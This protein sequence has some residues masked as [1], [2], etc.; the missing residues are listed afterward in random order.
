MHDGVGH[1]LAESA[2]PE[3][4]DRARL[5]ADEPPGAT[6]YERSRD[7]AVDGRFE[8]YKTTAEHEGDVG[9]RQHGFPI[10]GRGR[11]VMAR[12]RIETV[13]LDVDGTLVDSNGAHTQSWTQALVEHGVSVLPIEVRRLIGMGSDKLLPA[14]A[15][16][17]DRSE[18]GKAIIKRKKE[19]FD[20]LLPDLAPTPGAR[21]LLE[22]L[23]RQG[24]SLVV[25]TSGDD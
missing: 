1:R 8:L 10:P 19:L 21:P 4:A 9:R 23:L 15:Q 22:H 5:H 25:A 3:P 6:A 17:E 16:V 18:L 2:P 24:I 12:R 20:T 11:R 14:V 13:L 7:D